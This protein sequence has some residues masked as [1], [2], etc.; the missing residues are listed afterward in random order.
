MIENLPL[1]IPDATRGARTLTRCRQK[2][3]S[4]RRR[5]EARSRRPSRTIVALDRLLLAAC[6]LLYL[7]SMAD[8]V[9]RAIH[10]L[11]VRIGRRPREE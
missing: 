4:R 10:P 8:N 6:C 5:I 11:A 1:L 7:I 9:I 2:L 3:A